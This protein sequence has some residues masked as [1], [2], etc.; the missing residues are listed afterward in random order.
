QCLPSTT[1]TKL[2]KRTTT[3]TP[4]T[5]SSSSSSTKTATQT[6][7]Y[8]IPRATGTPIGAITEGTAVYGF[9]LQRDS[10]TNEAILIPDPYA[11]EIYYS[12]SIYRMEYVNTTGN[13]VSRVYL[14]I[15]QSTPSTLSYKQL[16]W[17]PNIGMTFSWKSD[18]SQVLQT[19]A[20]NDGF[21]LNW[22][23][24]DWFLAC[25]QDGKWKVYLQTGTDAPAGVTCVS[26]QLKLGLVV[27]E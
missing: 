20:T 6:C 10:S 7:P 23:A 24:H 15:Y 11:P 4:T 13:C 1:T 19:V 5:T 8:A 12:S 14:N 25:L 21:T 16:K 3:T 18:P 27:A 2:S 9:Y 17:Y 26:T 22:G